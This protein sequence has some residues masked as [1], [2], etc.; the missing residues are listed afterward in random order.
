MITHIFWI[1]LNILPFIYFLCTAAHVRFDSIIYIFNLPTFF[2]YLIHF[3]IPSCIFFIVFGF[4][5]IDTMSFYILWN[6][7]ND[8]LKCSFNFCRE[9]IFI[10]LK[11]FDVFF[12]YSEIF[13]LRPGLFVFFFFI[14]K[15]TEPCLDSVALPFR[16]SLL[17][18]ILAW[19]CSYS[20]L[21]SLGCW[22]QCQDL[23]LDIFGFKNLLSQFWYW[24]VFV[25]SSSAGL[26]K[27]HGFTLFFYHLTLL[28][29]RR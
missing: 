14:F 24:Q 6:T 2:P 4:Y 22:L 18:Y 23:K 28:R 1:S 21:C 20:R 8:I 26:K 7:I 17:A 9:I 16:L 15:W 19:G 3:L 29:L 10:V 5:F 11:H 25:Q 27:D 13:S 12:P